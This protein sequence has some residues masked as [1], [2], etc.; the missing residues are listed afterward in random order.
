MDMQ[1][2]DE[3]EA[4]ELQFLNMLSLVTREL[5]RKWL[6]KV[7]LPKNPGKI[8][9]AWSTTALDTTSMGFGDGGIP[10]MSSKSYIGLG[11]NFTTR[12]QPGMVTNQSQGY[13]NPANA[14]KRKPIPRFS[15]SSNA[16]AGQHPQSRKKPS[17][18]D[19]NAS[20][21]PRRQRT[22]SDMPVPRHRERQRSRS[23]EPDDVF[24]AV[25][26]PT[27]SRQNP[28]R[29]AERGQQQRTSSRHQ[30]T[31]SEQAA[32]RARRRREDPEGRSRDD[33]SPARSRSNSAAGKTTA[34]IHKVEAGSSSGRPRS[35]TSP[36]GPQPRTSTGARTR[37]E[38]LAA[39]E[40]L[41]R[42]QR[43]QQ[44]QQQQQQKQG[45]TSDTD[46]SGEDESDSGS[47][48]NRQENVPERTD[49]TR[50]AAGESRQAENSEESSEEEDDE[51]ES[52][53]EDPEQVL[54]ESDEE[55][56]TEVSEKEVSPTLGYFLT[57]TDQVQSILAIRSSD[58]ATYRM[59]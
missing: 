27:H 31:M 21:A 45:S 40:L 3:H 1:L 13:T 34:V 24:T 4:T 30:R 2:V 29:V 10:G 54:E 35:R 47:N 6:Q 22:H 58:I 11:Q 38:A 33:V 41:L 36:T 48:S 52:S 25:H 50:R 43:Q 16:T 17:Q 12:T 23:R 39:R 15:S 37:E 49:R 26:R 53:E 8:S 44:Q 7:K 56:N 59:L 32:D 19:L 20:H 55:G 9:K 42:Q 57:S 14:Q 51:E 28:G 5:T 18:A 46:D